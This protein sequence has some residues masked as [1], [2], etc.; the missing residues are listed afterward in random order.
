MKK[1]IIEI[2]TASDEMIDIIDHNKEIERFVKQLDIESWN[3]ME[4][5]PEDRD[6]VYRY[7]QVSEEIAKY[8]LSYLERSIE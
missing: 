3:Y 4:Q 1:K 2:I 6:L 7:I 8:I 5:F